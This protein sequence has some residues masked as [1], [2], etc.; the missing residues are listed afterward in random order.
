MPIDAIIHC[1]QSFPKPIAT[2]SHAVQEKAWIRLVIAGS[3]IAVWI[4]A[5]ILTNVSIACITSIAI[6]CSVLLLAMLA[7]L[8]LAALVIRT[9]YIVSV[10]Y[11]IELN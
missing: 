10:V 5:H 9:A 6:T 2:L 1:L 3:M 7:M 4:T 8:V 11:Q